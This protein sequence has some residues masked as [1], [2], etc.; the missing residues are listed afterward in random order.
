MEGG[1]TT[2]G[3]G[4]EDEKKNDKKRPCSAS[5]GNF[6]DLIQDSFTGSD[7]SIHNLGY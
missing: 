1:G 2:G 4:Q 7:D 6:I 5:R 3:K